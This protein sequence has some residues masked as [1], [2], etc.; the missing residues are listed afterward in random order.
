[1]I[2]TINVLGV[3]I[4]F[5]SFS[6]ICILLSEKYIEKYGFIAFTLYTIMASSP[7]AY[8]YS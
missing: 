3:L 1:M 5:A 6:E 8:F 2:T 7:Y 4:I